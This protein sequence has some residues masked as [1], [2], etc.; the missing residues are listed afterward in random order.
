MLTGHPGGPLSSSSSAD[1]DWV[2]VIAFSHVTAA[3]EC[4]VVVS[5]AP[6][7][8]VWVFIWVYCLSWSYWM[9]GN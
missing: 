8:R 7:T 6:H 4:A 9:A 1:G 3:R 2:A 5:P